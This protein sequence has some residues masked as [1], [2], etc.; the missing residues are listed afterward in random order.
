MLVA[1][2]KIDL[3]AAAEAWPAFRRARVGRGHR[4]GRDL[5][6]DRR[7]PRARSGRGSPT[8]CPTPPSSPS[9]P[10]RPASSSTAS[11]R[12]A[13]ASASSATR[14][15]RSGSA[16]SGSSGS[17]PRR[18][19]TSRN[20]PS[21]SSA[22]WRASASTPSCAGP[23]SS[24]ATSSGSAASSSSGRRSPGSAVTVD[25]RGALGIFGGTFDPIHVAHLAVAEEAR[26]G[27]RPRA[28]AVRARRR[29]A[30]QAGPRDHARRATG[31]RWSSWRSPTTPRFAVEPARA[32]PAG[33]VVHGR[34]ARGA[35]RCGRPRPAAPRTSS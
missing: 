6:G 10:S 3:P 34:H 26:D 30:A 29:A 17:R 16:A 24:P 4:R 14:T 35:S 33:A 22:T 20:R 27:A 15:G 2:N 23:G 13:T 11:R 21:G 1:F 7:G 32:R 18:T 19:S 8:C 9:R 25:R 28:G 12:W 5:R 31:W